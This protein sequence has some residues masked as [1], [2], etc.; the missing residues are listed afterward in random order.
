MSVKL[1]TKGR[2]KTEGVLRPGC[3]GE[4]LNVKREEVAGGWRRLHT[5]ELHNLCAS[6]NIIRGINSKR[7]GI[8][9]EFSTHVRDAKCIKIFVRK[10]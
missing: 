1:Y 3:G 4:Y 10:I 8:C 9:G 2:T 5:E 7:M 6:P